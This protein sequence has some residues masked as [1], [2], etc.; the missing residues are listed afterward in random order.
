MVE[1]VADSYCARADGRERD[2]SPLRIR[3]TERASEE[4][5]RART[6]LERGRELA[7]GA[8]VASEAVDTR[9]DEN[10]AE[11]GVL[12]VAVA[13]E[14]LAN[15]DGLL[16]CSGQ[17]HGKSGIQ[18]LRRRG[19]KSLLSCERGERPRRRNRQ[20]GVSPPPDSLT[21]YEGTAGERSRGPPGFAGQG[22]RS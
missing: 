15:L 5:S 21:R 9:L 2:Q 8:V 10:E 12:V 6:N 13:L 22:R 11:L 20:V 19:R 7:L 3:S 14:V 18:M 4:N 16:D 1:A 17:S